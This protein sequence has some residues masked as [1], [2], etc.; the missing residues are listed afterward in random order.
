MINTYFWIKLFL[1]V[2]FGFFLYRQILKSTAQNPQR[3]QSKAGFWTFAGIGG[4]VGLFVYAGMSISLIETRD[5]RT[6]STSKHSPQIV[7]IFDSGVIEVGDMVIKTDLAPKGSL[8]PLAKKLTD[9]CKGDQECEVQAMFDFVT[10]I[11]YKTDYT[12]RSPKSVLE[13]NWG[14][15]DDK[16]NLFASLLEEKGYQYALVYVPHHVFVAV[17]LD[18][19]SNLPL[20]KARIMIDQKPYYY[21]ETTAKNARIGEFNGQFPNSYL[22][23]YDL[24]NHREIDLDQISFH[25]I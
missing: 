11:P 2:L 23:I 19:P 1:L 16:T 21:A 20:L 10:T 7:S 3:R 13:S 22:G 15:C 24:H 25:L 17:H 9:P 6:V 14:D 5:L 4:A 18:D 12:S 8:E